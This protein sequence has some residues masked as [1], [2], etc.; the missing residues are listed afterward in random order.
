[1]KARQAAALALRVSRILAV[2]LVSIPLAW[3]AHLLEARSLNWISQNPTAFLKHEQKTAIRWSISSHYPS[4]E[5]STSVQSRR[6]RGA[7]AGFQIT[8]PPNSEPRPRQIKEIGTNAS[9]LMFELEGMKLRAAQ[10]RVASEK[11]S[12]YQVFGR[13]SRWPFRQSAGDCRDL[14]QLSSLKLLRRSYSHARP[15]KIATV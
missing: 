6:W 9:S 11:C 7:F 2:I 4:L 14:S 10:F 3:R 15:E 12:K 8:L 5:Q 1:M 13:S